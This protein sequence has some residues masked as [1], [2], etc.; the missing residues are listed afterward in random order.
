ML[1]TLLTTLLLLAATTLQ[2]AHIT[3]KLLVGLYET[4]NN[5]TKPLKVITSGTPLDVLKKDGGYSLVR[6]GDG[7]EGWIK[8]TYITAEKPAK[9]QL[10]ELQAK[11]GE[12]KQKL[13]QAEEKLKGINAVAADSSDSN[14]SKLQQELEATTAKLEQSESYAEKLRAELDANK[15]QVEAQA[16]ALI[17]AKQEAQT[18]REETKLLQTGSETDAASIRITR[19]ERDLDSSRK[20]EMASHEEVLM[21]QDHLKKLSRDAAQEK[22]AQA[23]IIE[24][25]KELNAAKEELNAAA[26]REAE[27]ARIQ[28]VAQLLQQRIKAALELLDV[29]VDELPAD[30]NNGS[31]FAPWNMLIMLL[32]LIGGFVGGVLFI[33]YRVRKRIGGFRI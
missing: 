10:L 11:T 12:L 20:A 4:P 5:S 24:L 32:F 29:P 22:L 17:N 9:A 27:N 8:S 21:L 16:K 19:L 28:S 31:L 13:Q 6:L 7:S 14:N 25:K 33:N 30:S 15:R 23:K 26:S 1:K 18:A 2:A 3:D